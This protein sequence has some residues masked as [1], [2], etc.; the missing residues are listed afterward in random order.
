MRLTIFL[1]LN[2]TSINLNFFFCWSFLL[3]FQYLVS[4]RWLIARNIILWWRKLRDTIRLLIR[5]FNRNITVWLRSLWDTLLFWTG[6]FRICLFNTWFV[7]IICLFILNQFILLLYLANYF[8][9]VIGLL[10]IIVMSLILIW[11]VILSWLIPF[12]WIILCC[13]LFFFLILSRWNAALILPILLLINFSLGRCLITFG[14]S[15][16]RFESFIQIVFV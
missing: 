10:N 14:H 13:F 6:L 3:T 11:N 8:D 7:I 4:M 5:L 12:I 2:K 15:L 9:I 16:L 1:D